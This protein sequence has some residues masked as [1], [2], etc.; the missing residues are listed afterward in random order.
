MDKISSI[1]L[2]G[3]NTALASCGARFNSSTSLTVTL[4]QVDALWQP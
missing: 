1:E 2:A 3:R 4:V